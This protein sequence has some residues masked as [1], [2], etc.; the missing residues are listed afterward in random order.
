[1]SRV[2]SFFLFLIMFVIFKVY[3][4]VSFCFVIIELPNDSKKTADAER[5]E[6]MHMY[7]CTV[8]M[9]VWIYMSVSIAL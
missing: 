1:M 5:N 9:Y 2:F 8:C 7:V 4:E 3:E 6:I